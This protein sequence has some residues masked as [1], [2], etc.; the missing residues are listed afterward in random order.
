MREKPNPLLF[1]WNRIKL[2]FIWIT[3]FIIG[4][5]LL[6]LVWSKVPKLNIQEIAIVSG[7]VIS[8]LIALSIKAT[9]DYKRIY[10]KEE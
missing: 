3:L 7:I 10:E 4:W 5:V 8:S 2:I 6:P 9:F 1:V